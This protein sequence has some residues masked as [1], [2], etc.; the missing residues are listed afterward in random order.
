MASYKT[1]PPITIKGVNYFDPRIWQ[2]SSTETSHTLPK[3]W[4]TGTNHRLYFV[5]VVFHTLDHIN[6]HVV[7]ELQPC[8][9]YVHLPG[10]MCLSI[11]GNW[12]SGSRLRSVPPKSVSSLVFC[13]LFTF[14]QHLFVYNIFRANMALKKPCRRRLW[15]LMLFKP[16]TNF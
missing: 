14:A 9:C 5:W 1:K 10:H 8:W 6:Q 16:T 2:P 12:G 7:V 3:D 4:P 11:I 13:S 15:H